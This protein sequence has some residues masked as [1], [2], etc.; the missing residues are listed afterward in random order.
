VPTKM[1]AT[2]PAGAVGRLRTVNRIGL[3]ATSPGPIGTP[4][5]SV[6][7][8]VIADPTGSVCGERARASNATRF[9]EPFVAKDPQVPQVP[10]AGFVLFYL[11]GGA[12]AGFVQI[13]TSEPYGKNTRCGRVPEAQAPSR[14]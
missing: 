3:P 4:D 10:G 12:A 9:V 13:A 2:E 14:S 8:T 1:R 5:A 11:S 7:S 6:T